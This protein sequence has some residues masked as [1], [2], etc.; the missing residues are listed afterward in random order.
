MPLSKL[1]E[2]S[3]H[4]RR[5]AAKRTKLLAKR[6]ATRP[7][8]CLHSRE[9]RFKIMAVGAHGLLPWRLKVGFCAMWSED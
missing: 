5:P 3:E 2:K 7:R 8:R 1:G 9:Q 4:S 6:V